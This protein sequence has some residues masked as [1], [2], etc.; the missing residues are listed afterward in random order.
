[1]FEVFDTAAISGMWGQNIGNYGHRYGRAVC[2]GYGL[3]CGGHFCHLLPSSG[4][5][6]ISA[7][8]A[9]FVALGV[10]YSCLRCNRSPE[11]GLR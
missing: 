5:R 2:G 7:G 8:F 10:L 9:A 4:C 11:S 1:M 6:T 3:A